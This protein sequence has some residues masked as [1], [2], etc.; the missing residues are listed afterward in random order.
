MND[1]VFRAVVKALDDG[2]R[3]ALVTIVSTSGSTPQRVGARMLVYEDGRSAGTIGGGCYENDA[4]GKAREAIRLSRPELVTYSLNEELAAESGL[5]CGGQMEVFI[6]PIVPVPDLYLLGAG[7]ISVEVARIARSTGF[8]VHVVD[9]RDKFASAERF[10]ETDVVVDDIPSWLK[11]ATL[12]AGAFVV[13]V[14]RGHRHDFEA[15]RELAGRPTRYLG[16]IGSRAKVLRIFEALEREGTDPGRLAAIHAPIGLDIGAVTPAE[17]AVSIVAE[18]IAVRSGRIAE[19][20]V[21]AAALRSS[22]RR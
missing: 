1:D 8:R 10:P 15:V 7:H 6:E 11:A 20:H 5:I 21:A 2:E 18:L 17:I 22:L 16:L 13:V 14:T 19:G 4:A 12:P 9:D 3:A